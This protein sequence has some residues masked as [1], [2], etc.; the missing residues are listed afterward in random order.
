MYYDK[1]VRYIDYL[2]NGEKRRNCGYVKAV[3]NNGSLLLQMQIKG[4]YETDDVTSEVTLEG[5]DVECH[6][7]TV[8]IR[9][10][11]GSFYREF[12]DPAHEGEEMEIKEGLSYG[13]LQRIV[14]QLSPRRSLRCIW[15]EVV[16]IGAVEPE[17]QIGS[18]SEIGLMTPETSDGSEFQG[19]TMALEEPVQSRGET[20]AT[21]SEQQA[22]S[23]GEID[24]MTPEKRAE[25]EPEA[26]MPEVEKL[27]D[28]EATERTGERPS[29][30]LHTTEANPGT[31]AMCE[32]KW[33]QLRR[34]YPH[35]YPFQDERE[36]LSLRPEDFVILSSDAYR[37]VR[38][39]FLL[40][41]YY[42]YKHLILTGVSQRG[43]EQY[44]IGVPGNF[45][46]K[47][48]QVAIM[49]GFSSFECKHEPAEEG[50]FGYYMIRVSI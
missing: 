22:Q 16:D 5:T 25:S 18:R 3:V 23:R 14:I 45:Y 36:Y 2:E 27:A 12:Q 41:G 38:N 21:T 42:N 9:Q 19:L 20:D 28:T 24:G 30:E 8:A 50:D 47:E 33:Q 31:M 39:S 37:L 4:L 13:Q 44:Y 35:I 17:E 26:Q 32:D 43:V 15:R 34:I 29:Q 7:G 1:R 6:I 48:K 46:E 10:G 49:Y 40:H 11:G